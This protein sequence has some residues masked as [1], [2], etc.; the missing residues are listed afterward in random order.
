M[1]LINEVRTSAKDGFNPY[2]NNGGTG[3]A[4]A[5]IDFAV[6]AG[7]SR[8]SSG[9]SIKT[10]RS[11][12][13]VK[14]TEKAALV[15][16][17]MQSDINTLRKT[18]MYQIELYKNKHGKDIEID[19]LASLLSRVLFSRRFFP[20][21]TFN[22][23]AGIDESGNG[24]V[25]GYDAIGSYEK[26][27]YGS[28]GTGKPLIDPVLDN[29]VA[30]K[31]RNDVD[32]FNLPPLTVEIATELV[33]DAITSAGERDIYTGDYVDILVISL[34]GVFEEIFELRFD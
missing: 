34:E 27:K 3:I 2:V 8:M 10:R 14:I 6:I 1:E 21:Y 23:L 18:L 17:G 26:M 9:Y 15:S 5:G 11:K 22:L 32:R 19:A 20:Y 4:V 25:F 28:V 12:K 24:C 30:F 13:V 29:Q 7:D 16:S 31:N 33:K